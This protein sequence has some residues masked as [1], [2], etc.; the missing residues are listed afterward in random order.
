MAL[1]R[2][3]F[4]RR[5]AS[6]T[7][8]IHESLLRRRARLTRLVEELEGLTPAQRARRLAQ[9]AGRLADAEQD[10]DDLDENARDAL[11][12]GATAAVEL[13]RLRAEIAAVGDLAGRVGRVRE[14]GRD[15]KL[16]ALRECL[17][18]A[19]FGELK[20]GRGKLLIFTEHRDVE[21]MFQPGFYLKLVNG[22]FGSSIALSDLKRPHRRILRRIEEYVTE[23][24][25]PDGAGFN[26]YRP[27]RYFAANAG[28][29]ERG[30]SEAELDRFQ[31]AFDAVNALLPRKS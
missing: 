25:L 22:A 23:H 6:S 29:V 12:D 10:E 19:E 30:L 26:H 21:D 9:L 14:G 3:V 27:A 15:S 24:P 8:A 4:Q 13:D 11:I 28:A 7:R 20:D 1:V 16:V 5:L 18:R 31:R 2:T 17:Q